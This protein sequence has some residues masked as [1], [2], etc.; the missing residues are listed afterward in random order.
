M[1]PHIVHPEQLQGFRLSEAD[2]CRLALLSAPCDGSSGSCDPAASPSLFLEI[3]DPCDRVPPHAHH[4]A[5]ELFFVLRGQ[6]SFR[7]S[8]KAISAG[9]GDFVMVPSET[10]HD[11]ENPGPE[12]LYL[13][14]VLSRDEGFAD[15]L[16][17]GIPTPLDAED[18]AVL[19]TL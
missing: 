10:L 19:R 8:E 2:H 11:L 18:L 1:L 12:R 16:Q 5:A 14:T 3:H 6:V 9:G 17:H 15:L 4:Q 7:L 13:L